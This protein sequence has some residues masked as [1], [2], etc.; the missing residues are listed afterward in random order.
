MVV[1]VPH[2]LMLRA[3]PV[4]R[5]PVDVVYEDQHV[6]VL[7]KPP[8]MRCFPRG[9]Y[10]TKT[11]LNGLLRYYRLPPVEPS[12]DGK[13]PRTLFDVA[14]VRGLGGFGWWDWSLGARVVGG[15]YAT[16]ADRLAV[17]YGIVR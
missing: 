7:N 16:S 1:R 17:L 14:R 8:G 10:H 3:L 11:L 13:L 4:A 12:V 15:S 2:G 5:L 9:P 6:V